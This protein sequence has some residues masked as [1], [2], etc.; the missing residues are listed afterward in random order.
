MNDKNNEKVKQITKILKEK[1]E[2]TLL[3][4][5]DGLMLKIETLIEHVLARPQPTII[6]QVP[7]KFEISNFGDAPSKLKIENF[8]EVQRVK[9]EMEVVVKNL[10]ETQK[11]FVVNEQKVQEVEIKNHQEVQ[12]VEVI[13]HQK[14]PEVLK[15]EVTN[16]DKA[17]TWVPEIITHAVKGMANMLTKLWA[18]G[19]TVRLAD[20]EILKP[21]PVF[22][23]D[24]Q[25]RPVDLSKVG[26][27]MMIPMLGGRPNGTVAIPSVINSGRAAVTTAGTPV[28]LSSSP[29]MSTKLY[30]TSPA[31]NGGY[32]Y[33]GGATVSAVGGSEQGVLLTPTGSVT[34]DISDLSKVWIDATEDGE[35]VSYTYV[36]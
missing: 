3:K 23:V 4:R 19:L 31:S 25:G 17:S 10:T 24:I 13:N 32:I 7:H 12:K 27:G 30:I 9:G 28:Q 6:T 21:K 33:V 29:I 35:G 26:G 36:K 15:V 8:P 1:S 2:S 20:E 34:L 5:I 18:E 11:V 14:S 16:Q 22:I